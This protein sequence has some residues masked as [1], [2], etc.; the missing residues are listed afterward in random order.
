MGETPAGGDAPLSV[1]SKMY[2]G[3]GSVAFGVATLGLSSAV[4]QPYLNRVIG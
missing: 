1:R 2:Y 4:L 3:V